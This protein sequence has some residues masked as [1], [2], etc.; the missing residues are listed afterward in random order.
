MSF[1]L[2]FLS[3]FL[4]PPF[5]LPLPALCSLLALSFRSWIALWPYRCF[6]ILIE[7]PSAR[8]VVN[9]LVAA[10]PSL[11]VVYRIPCAAF[12]GKSVVIA[13]PFAP[14]S[15]AKTASGGSR[16]IVLLAAEKK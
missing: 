16:S 3:S 8:I 2:P 12:T 4:C 14:S 13:P 6:K 7:P 1:P 15:I 5:A 11:I 9:N 10:M